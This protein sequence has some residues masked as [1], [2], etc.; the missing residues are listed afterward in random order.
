MRIGEVALLSGVTV[1]ALHHYDKIGLLRPEGVTESGYR[2]YGTKE[3]ERLQ[4]IMFFRE[5]DFSLDEIG[6]ILD[7]P[8]YDKNEVLLRHRTM[9]VSKRERIDGLIELVDKTLKGEKKMSFK[10]F[11]AS[12]MDAERKKY[13]DEARAR[14]GNTEAYKESEKRA[15]GRTEEQWK[16][17]DERG[18]AILKEFSVNRH[19]SPKSD[20]A[21]ALVKKWQDY[22]SKNMYTCTDEILGCLGQMYVADE[23][24]KSNLDLNGEGTAEFM[25]AAIEKYTKK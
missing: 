3:L 11:D 19:L 22:I 23:R 25:A 2:V 8:D 1:R 18:A 24:F 12:K 16:A 20:E 21:Q 17:F 13:A 7:A 4:Q 6:A 14:W 9:L 5:L 10:E 15:A